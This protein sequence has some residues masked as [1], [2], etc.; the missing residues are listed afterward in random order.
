MSE[1]DDH[2]LNHMLIDTDRVLDLQAFSQIMTHMISNLFPLLK[3]LH[4]CDHSKFISMMKQFLRDS[5]PDLVVLVEPCISG[6]NTDSVI[7]SLSFLHTHRIKASGFSWGIWLARYGS[8]HVEVLLNH[9]QFIHCMVTNVPCGKSFLV[10][11]VYANRNASKRYALWRHLH[12]M[13][14][15][16]HLP[17]III[18]DFNATLS[19]FIGKDVL[20]PRS[21]VMLFKAFYSIMAFEMWV[22]KALNSLGL[23]VP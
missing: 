10:T 3:K 13:G 19:I 20:Y 9:F 22:S 8:L 17:W 21:Q 4:G 23:E 16:I 18:G 15:S 5:Q 7:H 14:D 1:N 11:T 6:R 2:N 12:H